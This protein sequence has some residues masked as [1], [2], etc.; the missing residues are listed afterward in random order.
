MKERARFVVESEEGYFTIAELCGRYGI[1]RKT[2]YKWMDRFEREGPSG[3]EDRPRI[4]EHIPHRTDEA[5]AQR[6]IAF[7]RQHPDWGPKKLLA[8]LRELHP[9]LGWPAPS[10]AGDILTRAG[11]TVPRRRRRLPLA[12]S[13]QPL[14][15]PEAPNDLWSTD[16]KGQFRTGDRL[17][18]YPLTVC[19]AVSRYILDVRALLS[20]E[21]LPARKSFERL[22]HEYGLPRVLRSDNG[23]PFAS[24][25][26]CRLSRLSVWW[27]RLGIRP[28]R[29]APAHPEQNGSH[30][31][32]HRT[33][34]AATT[35]PPQRNLSA[36]Q[37]RFDDF[38][39]EFNDQRPH[40]SLGQKTPAS[41]Y[42][43]SP[44]I[45]PDRL[46]ALEYPG[47]F[48]VRRVGSN[49]CILWKGRRLAL[50]HCLSGE[51]V[52][53]EEVDDGVWSLFFSQ[54]LLARFDQHTFQLHPGFP[55]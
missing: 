43:P 50:S 55:A 54:F 6:V 12:P 46:P 16:F 39:D 18:C 23:V 41:V 31:R 22:F 29:I 53:L 11:L 45:Y 47:H 7:R 1:S 14:T 40:E 19:D 48:Q 10:T 42:R 27:I 49:G 17:Y 32:M 26:L 30:E 25:G 37:R 9:D 33:L 2:G 28:E 20:T 52:G 13:Q 38:R 3:L 51:D 34:K 5:I 21:T 36:Q 24:T 44:R 15:R 35:R 4:A 8:R